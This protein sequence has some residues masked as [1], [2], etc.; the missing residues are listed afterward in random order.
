MAEIK[1][2]TITFSNGCCGCDIEEEF[3][4]TYEEA[5]A[6][7]NEYIPDYAEGYTHAAFGW[8]GEYTEEEYEDYVA[9]CGY[10]IAESEED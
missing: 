7:A 10:H 9:D 2:W 3:E 6:W 1:T 8:D 5:V 4:G